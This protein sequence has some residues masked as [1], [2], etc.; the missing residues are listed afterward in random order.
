MLLLQS[1]KTEN[2]GETCQIFRDENGTWSWTNKT[3]AQI[4]DMNKTVEAKE[5]SIACVWFK[6]AI[7]GM[8]TRNYVL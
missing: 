2:D 1:V 8:Y 5:M 4:D 3:T 7:P 6:Y